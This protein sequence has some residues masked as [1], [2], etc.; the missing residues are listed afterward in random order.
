M[1]KGLLSAKKLHSRSW[2][3]GFDQASENGKIQ[4]I[5]DG[6]KVG[7]EAKHK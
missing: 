2:H 6:R 3:M 7:E 4:I 5:R 1:S